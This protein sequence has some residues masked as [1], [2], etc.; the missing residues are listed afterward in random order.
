[1][2]NFCKSFHSCLT[3]SNN[4]LCIFA[5]C[6]KIFSFLFLISQCA[7]A[8]EK[9]ELKNADQL[10]GKV[11]DGQNV[12][13]ATGNVEFVQ[14]N[15]KVFCNSAT[16][17]IE[18]NRV[19]LRGNVRIYQDT[20]S[21]LT[22]KATYFGDD[23]RAVCESGVT[24]KDPNATLRADNGVYFF[25]EAKAIFKGD[26]II[27]NPQ[28]RITSNEITYFRN[29][30]DSFARGNVIVTTDSATIKA[31]NIDFFKRQGK[32]YALGNVRIE[33]DSTVITSDTATNFSS[34][35]KSLA[36][37]NVRIVSLN[38]N[39]VISGRVL[40]NY[41]KE[42]YT[43]IKD[44]AK[45]V[46]A[47]DG[48]DSLYIFCDTMQ[49]FRVKPEYYTASGNVE[50]IR[51]NFLSKC[52][53]GVYYK[54]RETVSL[55][56]NPVVWQDRLQVTGD[57]IYAELPGNKLQ[58]IFVKKLL[59]V[60]NS[61]TSFVISSNEDEYF[62]DRFDQIS[63][64]DITLNLVNDKIN[65]INVEGG[66]NSIYFVYEEDEANGLN[67]IEG[68]ELQI[69][70]DGDE[71]V[72]RIKVTT[73]PKGEYVPEALLNTVNLILPGFGLREDKPLKR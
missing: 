24:L 45:L 69:F 56:L 31:D 32:T 28:Y 4:I 18:A 13:E 73:D 65:L 19:E 44:N 71:K 61:K 17:F 35:K 11:I 48:K 12:R 52:G 23:K 14:G 30:E 43:I 66:S 68:E 5:K 50:I 67:N 10:S 22:P 53:L 58:T 3:K 7:E 63:G 59:T 55:S 40:E 72:S 16:Q 37:G 8:Q 57:S 33:S 9:I 20:L 51:D 42:N 70:F 60:P 25:N 41:E 46:Q 62:K 21:L 27:V 1:M 54:N 26:V 6:I 47:E 64:K 49:A 29:N 2:N 39:T 15:V 38:N 34:E 36:N